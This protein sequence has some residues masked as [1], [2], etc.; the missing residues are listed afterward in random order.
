M[1]QCVIKFGI[2]FAFAVLFCGV[3][4]NP[5]LRK[6][7]ST[8]D[9]IF[10]EMGKFRRDLSFVETRIDDIEEMIGNI[11][12]SEEESGNSQSSSDTGSS[13]LQPVRN[14]V[15]ENE[16]NENDGGISDEVKMKMNMA[17]KSLSKEKL[18]I[19]TMV[20]DLEKLVRDGSIGNGVEER[21]RGIE[22][23]LKNNVI[24]DAGDLGKGFEAGNK[25]KGN[26]VT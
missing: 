17:L 4:G 26:N 22:D 5:R 13:D 25:D 6:M 1:R 9:H 24:H 15:E 2:L 14:H 7:Q 11:T 21:I 19:R 8:I 10:T 20:K 3:H 23:K 18:Y 16:D 12:L